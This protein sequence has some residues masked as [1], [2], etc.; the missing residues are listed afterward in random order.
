M[1][2]RCHKIKAITWER[3]RLAVFLNTECRHCLWVKINPDDLS[4]PFIVSTNSWNIKKDNKTHPHT[5]PYTHPHQDTCTSD[6]LCC[7]IGNKGRVCCWDCIETF[8]I[9]RRGRIGRQ[10]GSHFIETLRLL[11]EATTIACLYVLDCSRAPIKE[12][13]VLLP[14][15]ASLSLHVYQRSSGTEE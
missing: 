1:Q 2:T 12:H 13:G 10:V 6:Y 11:G 8:N 7:T 3:R 4:H 15:W 5:D 14:L 9:R